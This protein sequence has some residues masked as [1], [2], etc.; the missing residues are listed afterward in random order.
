MLNKKKLTPNAKK[1]KE[2]FKDGKKNYEKI[3]EIKKKGPECR[4]KK[5]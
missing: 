4:R 2:E 3:C 1:E 5:E